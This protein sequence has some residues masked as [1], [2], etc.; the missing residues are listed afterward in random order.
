MDQSR[1]GG[2]AVYKIG[3]CGKRNAFVEKWHTTQVLT[4]FLVVL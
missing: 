4:K 1:G 3:N 2:K